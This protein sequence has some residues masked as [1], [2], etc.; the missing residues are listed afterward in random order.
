MLY[1]NVEEIMKIIVEEG[2]K[3]FYLGRNPKHGPAFK[4]KRYHGSP[5]SQ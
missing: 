2:V 1:P 3:M 4:R 5:C